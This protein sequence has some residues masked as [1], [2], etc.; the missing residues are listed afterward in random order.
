MIKIDEK[1]MKHGLL[2]LVIA[3][4][5]VIRDA[6]RL[7]A[8]KRTESQFLTEEEIE[9]LGAALADLDKAIE[10]MKKEQGVTEAVKNVRDG[11][12]NIANDV[13][14][15]MINPNKWKERIKEEQK[16]EDFQERKIKQ[17]EAEI[18]TA[19]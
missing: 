3:L 2:G 14:N 9:R 1:N 18:L 13:I 5:E 17:K 16:I 19:K 7:Q 10:E 8:I 15:K 11:L 4:V 12:D 6:L